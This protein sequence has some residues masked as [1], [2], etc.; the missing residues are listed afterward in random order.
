MSKLKELGPHCAPDLPEH[1][2]LNTLSYAK[3]REIAVRALRS[4]C[5]MTRGPT[6]TA[7]YSL[8]RSIAAPL[9]RNTSD[10][11]SPFVRHA[12]L[13]PGGRYLLCQVSSVRYNELRLLDLENEDICVWSF[14]IGT[15]SEALRNDRCLILSSI[16]MCSDEGIIVAIA[17]TS[18]PDHAGNARR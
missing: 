13:S 12:R 10:I 5:L 2:D 9:Q 1:I 8:I 4:Y 17:G 16:T 15:I 7:N 18:D 14:D 6:P 11:D 3:V